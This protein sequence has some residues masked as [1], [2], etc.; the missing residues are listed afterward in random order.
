[1]KI[2]CQISETLGLSFQNTCELNQI[3]DQSLP[4]VPQ[5]Q[6]RELNIQGETIE[7]YFRDILKCIEALYGNPEFAPHLIFMPERHYS[8]AN[9][10]ER[11]FHDMHTGKWWWETQVSNT[12]SI[13]HAAC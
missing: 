4:G 13:R 1:M 11:V 8:D 6:R 5:F 9:R 10:M 12:Y 2:R 7:L 3:I